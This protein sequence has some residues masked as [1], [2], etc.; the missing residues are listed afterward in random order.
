M[1]KIL[2][3]ILLITSVL[4]PSL[5]I[6]QGIEFNSN[7]NLI[8]NRTSYN[9]FE[10]NQP[11]FTGA[12]S[13][14]FSL[15]IN[16]PLSFGY[17]SSIKN[18][19]SENSYSISYINTS[20]NSGQ[21]KFNLDA[22]KNIFTIPIEAERLGSKRW[23]DITI[24]FNSNENNIELIVNNKSYLYEECVFQNSI[25]PEIYFGKHQ[26]VIEVPSMSI[27]NL[28]IEN[29]GEN[30]VFNFNE[31]SGEEVF[32][33]NGKRYGK[34]LHANW[35]ISNSYYWKHRYSFTSKK[36]ISVTYDE[37]NQKFVFL[38]DDAL[39]VYDFRKEDT[40]KKL[41]KNKLPVPMRLG[42]SIL[43]CDANKLYVYEVND[44]A[45][46]GAT[47]AHID[48]DSLVWRVN[49]TEQ[50]P[51]QRHHHNA[52]F[53]KSEDELIIFGGFGNQKLTNNFNTF[54]LT[55]NKWNL[56]RFKG[57]TISPR[58]FSGSTKIKDTEILLFGGMGNKT[59]D[60]SIGKTYYYD[61][62]KVNLETKTIKKLWDVKRED[63]NMV[64]SRNM[65][66]TTDST[67]FYTLSYPEYIAATHLQL[68]KYDIKNGDYQILGDSI[69]MVSERIRTNA[70]LYYNKQTEELFCVAQ[71]FEL[72]G[73]NKVNIY[74]INAP[75]VSKAVIYKAEN[76]KST[77]KNLVII[78]LLICIPILLIAIYFL[79]R[80]KKQKEIISDQV[81]IIENFSVADKTPTKT[82]NFVSVFG[83]FTVFDK[84][85]KDISYMFSPKIRQLFLYL[86]FN[87][88]KDEQTGVTSEKLHTTLWP[89]STPQKAKNL[90][91]VTLNQLRNILR[92]LSDIEVIYS[93]GHFYMEFGD[94]FHCDYFDFNTQ[95]N[96]VKQDSLDTNSLTKFVKL[97]RSGKFLKAINDECF[98]K[99]KENFEYEILEIIPNQLKRFYK[100]K[101]YTSVIGLT[102]ILYNIDS[103]SEMA[104]Y[105]RMHAYNKMGM[106]EKAKKHF[107]NFNYRYKKLIGDDFPHTFNEVLKKIPKHL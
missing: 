106:I 28:H 92:E 88:K 11:K 39:T 96:L 98:D 43:D 8:S 87:S 55:T 91:N 18:K 19:E 67:A 17:I 83:D 100:E 14:K 70:N 102:D 23:I 45:D 49:S 78:I 61:C 46:N 22:V 57:D 59:G 69:P 29:G 81:K 99:I 86:F 27:K 65:V 3:R 52:I 32:D 82:P 5:L 35:L 60:P 15:S 93:Y 103:I 72:D 24:H 1:C 73:S 10:Y 94:A 47:V 75:P 68:Y 25:V 38:K 12:F 76:K 79:K 16:D 9:V 21:I 58:Y 74:S 4:F 41:L 89:D 42:T 48:L 63:T 85:G 13:F 44:V 37:K 95:L 7:D 20:P 34:I 30:Y 62:Y 90:K 66:L 26:N 71:E 40:I 101:N 51:T 56:Q 54:N 64:S 80:K 77:S 50:L 84:N 97:A 105:Y 36:V 33:E 107:N 6:A 2:F 31:S 104:F 53:N